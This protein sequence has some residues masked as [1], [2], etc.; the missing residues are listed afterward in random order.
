MIWEDKSEGVFCITEINGYN[1]SR[2]VTEE[3][4][5]FVG[6]SRDGDL[7][8]RDAAGAPDTLAINVTFADRGGCDVRTDVAVE[9]V[10]VGSAAEV[11]YDDFGR[12]DDRVEGTADVGY[13]LDGFGLHRTLFDNDGAFASEVEAGSTDPCYV[14]FRCTKRGGIACRG[15][16]PTMPALRDAYEGMRNPASSVL[17][18][19][20]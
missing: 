4:F 19:L 14:L 13:R 18:E 11:M 12:S 16:Y 5:Y 2:R 7:M 3:E 8:P 17:V 20:D 9:K 6:Q 1:D 15:Q 10:C